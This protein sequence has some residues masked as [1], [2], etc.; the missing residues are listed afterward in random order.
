MSSSG[1][2]LAHSLLAPGDHDQSRKKQ[3]WE[4]PPGSGKLEFMGPSLSAAFPGQHHCLPGIKLP[5]SQ[6]ICGLAQGRNPSSRIGGEAP[7]SEAHLNTHP[8][9]TDFTKSNQNAYIQ[10]RLPLMLWLR[11]LRMRP[12]TPPPPPRSLN[13][14]LFLGAGGIHWPAFGF[15]DKCLTLYSL[16]FICMRPRC[17]HSCPAQGQAVTQSPIQSEPSV[18]ARFQ[19]QQSM[20]W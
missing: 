6:G 8:A 16:I 20:R 18:A 4:V 10:C 11:P 3:N 17:L 1:Q 9:T 14:A 13:P 19:Q 15:C 7:A 2:V 5:A 12:P